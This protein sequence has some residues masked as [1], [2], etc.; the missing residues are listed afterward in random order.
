MFY[1]F[2]ISRYDGTAYISTMYNVLIYRGQKL[3]LKFEPHLILQLKTFRHQS[4][5]VSSWMKY[6]VEMREWSGRAKGGGR[7]YKGIYGVLLGG[8]SVDVLAT[9]YSNS[10]T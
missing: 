5:N 10:I 1:M 8:R 2:T 4:N 3:V 9:Y 6:Y 7:E